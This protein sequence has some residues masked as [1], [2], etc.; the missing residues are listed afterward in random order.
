MSDKGTDLPSHRDTH[1]DTTGTE[2]HDSGTLHLLHFHQSTKRG[3]KKRLDCSK[4]SNTPLRVCSRAVQF[5]YPKGGDTYVHT[6][7]RPTLVGWCHRLT[8][9]VAA[10]FSSSCS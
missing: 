7:S 6:S 8:S 5:I 1:R 2:P 3:D 4:T 10:R 9:L